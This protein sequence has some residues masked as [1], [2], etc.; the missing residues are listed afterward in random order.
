MEEAIQ[1]GRHRRVAIGTDQ[2]VD[3][4]PEKAEGY[5]EHPGWQTAQGLQVRRAFR[6]DPEAEPL[7]GDE[8][9]DRNDP[10]DQEVDGR[11]DGVGGRL[12]W[13]E[14]GIEDDRVEHDQPEEGGTVCLQ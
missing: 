14:E 4:R 2:G 10:S 12:L 1:R 8:V 11:E 6:R 9:E 5:D 13:R 7:D 3:E